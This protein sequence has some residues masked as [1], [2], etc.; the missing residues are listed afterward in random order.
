[1]NPDL[2]ERVARTMEIDPRL[3]PLL[4][5]LLADLPELGSSADAVVS[6]LRAVGVVEGGSAL[7]LGCGKG[8]VSV[9]LAERL[10]LFVEGVDAFPPFL[11]AARALAAERGVASRCVFREGDIRDLL[12]REAHHDAVLLLS[13]GPVV[14]DHEKT[15]AGLRTL[16]RPGGHLVIEDGFLA[17]G[18]VRA[19]G[20]EA[21]AGRDETLR[22]LTAFGDEVVHE[23]V[24]TAEET[25]SQNER[26][27][28]L[29]RARAR[30]LRERH[31]DLARPIDEYVARQ[32]RET[33][34]LGSDVVCALWVLRRG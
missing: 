31:P 12:G 33:R 25:R 28:E 8:A 18:A 9:A 3:L 5:D 2:A 15:M 24:W 29:I 1:V 32:E 30:G 19:S 34:V 6:A 17:D 26:N 16:A 13:V 23:V 20:Y 4:A 14:A 7:D 27:T 11:E 21:H 22:R 10:G